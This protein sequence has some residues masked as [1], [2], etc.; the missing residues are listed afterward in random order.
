MARS[1]TSDNLKSFTHSTKPCAFC[2]CR[3][4]RC[5]CLLHSIPAAHCQGPGPHVFPPG[6]WR[7]LLLAFVSV[8]ACE[9]APPCSS[10]ACFLELWF[11]DAIAPWSSFRW[12]VAASEGTVFGHPREAWLSPAFNLYTC[13]I[14]YS[15]DEWNGLSPL[16]YCASFPI[17][18]CFFKN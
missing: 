9:S 4:H 17:H 10:R 5:L 3:S 11:D 8:P 18:V 15:L 13:A 1:V 7:L 6:V 14:L 2:L 16:K 12:V